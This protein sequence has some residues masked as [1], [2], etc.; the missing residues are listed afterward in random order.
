MEAGLAAQSQVSG[1]L[2]GEEV[3]GRQLLAFLEPLEDEFRLL[4]R[5]DLFRDFLSDA[6]A[7]HPDSVDDLVVIVDLADVL[8]VL[9]VLL[10]REHLRLDEL[11]LRP[12]GFPAQAVALLVERGHLVVLRLGLLRELGNALVGVLGEVSRGLQFVLHLPDILVLL[13]R[14]L[15][16]LDLRLQALDLVDQRAFLVDRQDGRHLPKLEALQF[17]LELPERDRAARELPPLQFAELVLEL[18]HPAVVPVAFLFRGFDLAVP[19]V[20]LDPVLGRLVDE[21][22]DLGIQGVALLDPFPRL[23]IQLVAAPA[24]AFRLLVLSLPLQLKI[25]QHRNPLET[26]WWEVAK[27]TSAYKTS[28]GCSR[29]PEGTQA[30]TASQTQIASHFMVT[31]VP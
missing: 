19:F 13:E 24:V 16:F 6:A 31:G 1:L 26:G 17:L 23:V 11:L 22:A 27:N 3:L 10:V 29:N 30:I 2:E 5:V 21:G 15:E 8:D 18:V 9:A 12:V 4:L 14:L 7:L 28:R 25:I 20:P